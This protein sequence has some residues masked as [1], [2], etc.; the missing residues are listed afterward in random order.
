MRM[1][2]P[3]NWDRLP[4]PLLE[5]LHKHECMVG[6]SH[7][8]DWR[9]VASYRDG[10]GHIDEASEQQVRRAIA[11]AATSKI[12]VYQDQSDKN[13]RVYYSAMAAMPEHK[14]LDLCYEIYVAG[15]SSGRDSL[16]RVL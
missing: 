1:L 6:A 5:I 12:T 11:H 4:P 9:T 2:N 3:A 10:Q 14:F 7:T 15:Q 13:G 16:S 8:V